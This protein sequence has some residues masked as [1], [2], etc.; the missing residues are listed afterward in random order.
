MVSTGEVGCL[1]D[2]FDEAFL[3][4]L[5]SVGYRFPL[6]AVL[7][8]TGRIQE[9]VAFLQGA[10][11]LRAIGVNL[12]ATPGS[13]QFLLQN[14]IDV[15]EVG[16]PD[17]DEGLTANDLIV[18]RKVDL[19]VNI[20]KN[21]LYDELS[22]DVHIRTLTVKYNL[23]LVTNIQLASRLAAALA[24]PDVTYGIKS[25]CEYAKGPDP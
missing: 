7:L 16:W 3:K 23:P 21:N 17:T 24:N 1:G 2:D 6:R 18:A 25:L 10:A 11:Q 15:Q 8:S 5:M 9:K 22:N 13:A 14:G 4:S 12:F 19:V 20:P